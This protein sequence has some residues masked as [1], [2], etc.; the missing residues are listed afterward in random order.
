M[1]L[2]MHCPHLN[3]GHTRFRAQSVCKSEAH[4][5]SLKRTLQWGWIPS[6]WLER[7][8]QI[9]CSETSGN[10]GHY[11]RTYY[12]NRRISGKVA[13]EFP[14]GVDGVNTSLRQVFTMRKTSLLKSVVGPG[15]RVYTASN[16]K[17][18]AL[19][20][21][22]ARGR[23]FEGLVSSIGGVLLATNAS[24]IV[25][26][27]SPL[28]VVTGSLT[29]P[30][31]SIVNAGSHV[32]VNVLRASFTS[33][34]NLISLCLFVVWMQR[35]GQLPAETPVVLSQVAFRV[36]IP[37]FL[38][39]KVAI[40]L[41]SQPAANLLFLPLVAIAQVLT[42]AS[43]GRLACRFVYPAP[44]SASSPNFGNTAPITSVPP[45]TI[46]SER[47]SSAITQVA[48]SNNVI[49]FQE[50]T[51][52]YMAAKKEAIVTAAC[53]FGNSFTL[54]LIFMTGVLAAEEASKV[55]GYL[56]L[57]MVGWSPAL[58][59]VGYSLIATGDEESDSR[60]SVP[61]NRFSLNA[62]LEE[63]KRIM[64]P[65]LYGVLVGMLVGGTPL[66]HLFL[67]EA[68]TSA[69]TMKSTGAFTVLCTFTSGIL[70][71][72]FDAAALLGTATL[73]VQ[74]IVLASSL[75]TSIPSLSTASDAKISSPRVEAVEHLPDT[76]NHSIIKA[77]S[78][79]TDLETVL[80]SR[81]FWIISSVRLVAMPIIMVVSTVILQSARILPADPV[82][83]LLLMAQSAMPSAQNL[84]LLSQLR[85]STRRLSGVLAS[86]LL[87]QRMN[88]EVCFHFLIILRPEGYEENCSIGHSNV[89]P[90]NQLNAIT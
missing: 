78:F 37:C 26:Q 14:L 20:R 70:R 65:P 90:C 27:S 43:L 72:I 76:G 66:S 39:T 31:A 63:I 53:A 25:L 68:N 56:A 4:Q 44:A 10:S 58:W 87:R 9:V 57:F 81:A 61:K 23:G 51:E 47:G 21:R 7:I 19:L 71:P 18:G 73:A 64:N 5:A 45:A 8:S 38:M 49:S 11:H 22:Q 48:T 42:G 28:A 54:P 77:V 6:I 74:T 12:S 83:N 50:N 79:S 29:S 86:L 85:T 16:L 89:I 2:R 13:A 35:S 33:S 24:S 46:I 30:L 84:V 55:A 88:F 3:T 82:Y 40:T 15:M 80:D 75:A 36:L 1:Y 59:I 62:I 67:S 52:Q 41:A 34:L 32:D 17:R 69:I 60:G